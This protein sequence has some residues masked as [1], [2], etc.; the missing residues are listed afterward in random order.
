M[1]AAHATARSQAA[2]ETCNDIHALFRCPICYETM[3]LP[4]TLACGHSFCTCCIGPWYKAELAKLGGT[5][6]REKAPKCP[7]CRENI[8]INAAALKPSALLI[9]LHEKLDSIRLSITALEAPEDP[10]PAPSTAAVATAESASSSLRHDGCTCPCSCDAGP[11]NASVVAYTSQIPPAAETNASSISQLTVAAIPMARVVTAVA[12]GAATNSSAAPA[13]PVAAQ[14][15]HVPTREN[16]AALAAL[17]RAQQL[18]SQIEAQAPPPVDVIRAVVTAVVA[19]DT[20][21]IIPAIQ[22]SFISTSAA[23]PLARSASHPTPAADGS[24]RSSSSSSG[25]DETSSSSSQNHLDIGSPLRS[26]SS[27]SSS[28]SSGG[29]GTRTDMTSPCGRALTVPSTSSCSSSSSSSGA[30]VSRQPTEE[31]VLRQAEMLSMQVN[32]EGAAVTMA[33]NGHFYCGRH[34]RRI[35]GFYNGCSACGT[36]CGPDGG[37]NCLACHR[38]DLSLGL[39]NAHHPLPTRR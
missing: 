25:G 6:T 27:A 10:A 29:S 13:P 8:P 28:A 12:A 36:H 5:A 26:P 19:P 31:Q 32:D 9:A 17:R 23:V 16:P 1:A 11:L 15:V 39:D 22:H 24:G 14:V 37:C 21:T 18:S 34:V 7:T 2:L 30:G 33:A 4:V 38:L 35:L 3:S 20:T